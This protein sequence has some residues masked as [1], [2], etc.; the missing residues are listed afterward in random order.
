[1]QLLWR[2]GGL[3]K[4]LEICIFIALLSAYD[5]NGPE[6]TLKPNWFGAEASEL[7]PHSWLE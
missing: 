6:T 2:P 7:S 5:A 3:G 1:M 4:S